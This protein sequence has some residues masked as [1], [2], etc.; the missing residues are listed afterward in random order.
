MSSWHS[1]LLTPCNV[2]GLLCSKKAATYYYTT[3]LAA[4]IQVCFCLNLFW[5]KLSSIWQQLIYITNTPMVVANYM[6]MYD[7][8]GECNYTYVYMLMI[9][10]QWEVNWTL[11]ITVAICCELPSLQPETRLD[12]WFE[13]AIIFYI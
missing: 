9:I 3:L 13:L 12:L 11:I 2:I 1:L 6:I 4:Y 10:Y 8:T 7:L 5:T